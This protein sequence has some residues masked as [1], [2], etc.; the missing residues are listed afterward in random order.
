MDVSLESVLRDREKELVE[1][2][3][4]VVTE[5]F[6]TDILNEERHVR[7][8]IRP[9]FIRRYRIDLWSWSFLL[10]VEEGEERDVG[11]FDDLESDTGNITDGVTG[12]TETS[13]K[14]FI[15]FFNVIQATVIWYE[16]GDL[17]AIFD[18]LKNLFEKKG[19]YFWG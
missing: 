17:F 19:I 2:W 3:V 18:K 7:H 11:D 1:L 12:T 10:A 8:F 9:W 13:D 16:S 14:N 5:S 6:I 15:V 4:S